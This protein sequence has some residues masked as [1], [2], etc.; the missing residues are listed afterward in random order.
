MIILSDFDYNKFLW[1]Y[2]NASLHFYK[3]NSN[4]IEYKKRILKLLKS[5]ME[6]ING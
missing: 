1:C 3:M 5:I 6:D 4:N 2:I